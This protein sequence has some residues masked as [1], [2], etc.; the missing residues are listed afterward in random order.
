MAASVRV[1]L[2]LAVAFVA[3]PLATTEV[4]A[5]G[6]GTGA[7]ALAGP[8]SAL[9]L[10]SRGAPSAPP[11]P[12]TNSSAVVADRGPQLASSLAAR[13]GLTYQDSG[14]FLLLSDAICRVRVYPNSH[15]LT[16]DGEDRTL[17]GYLARSPQ[18][19]TLPGPAAAVVEAHV[20]RARAQRLAPPPAPVV[21]PTPKPAPT[22]KP[23]AL[24][25]HLKLP[26][27]AP[28]APAAA[29]PV[30]PDPS[31]VVAPTSRAWKWIVL[32]HST[33]PAETS[34]S[35]TGGISP[36]AGSTAAATTS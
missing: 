20:L 2:S 28:A 19:V 31:W 15:R 8:G 21:A 1:V 27:M 29:S 4:M 30:K 24:P 7:V 33:T 5:D 9:P 10:A 34:R 18:G 36:R 26:A 14:S 6:T 17:R 16:L 25:A 11:P 3:G 32:H 35:T 13:L 23:K 12:G 22:S